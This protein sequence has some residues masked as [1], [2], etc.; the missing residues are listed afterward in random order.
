MIN[1]L[2]ERQKTKYQYGLKLGPS[3][4]VH[5]F[6]RR[7]TPFD[8]SNHSIL[9]FSYKEWTIDMS[10][11]DGNL[12]NTTQAKYVL[13]ETTSTFH[14]QAHSNTQAWWSVRH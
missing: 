10:A 1:F 14:Q 3:R 2:S 5:V 6:E 4:C 13:P 7:L 9:L 8:Y 11:I 12:E